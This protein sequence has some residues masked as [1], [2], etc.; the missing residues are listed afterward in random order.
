MGR[1][2]RDHEQRAETTN[3]R[4]RPPWR[5]KRRPCETQFDSRL[6]VDEWSLPHG[7]TDPEGRA[8]TD[9]PTPVGA[10]V[11]GLVAGAIGTAAMDVLLFTRYRRDGGK[12]PFA[13]WELSSGL[14]GW[15]DAPAPAQVGKRLVE[16]LFDL[17][18]PPERAPLV[19]NLTHWGFGMLSGAQYGLVAGSLPRPRIGYGL[20]FGAIVWASGYVVLPAAKLYEPIWKYD[21]KTLGN[22]LRAHLVYGLATAAAWRLISS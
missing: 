9:A 6:G 13:H 2:N 3:R 16:G 19:N 22:D 12:T 21:V 1:P 10:V 7:R 14:K 17:E 11:R 8:V 18:L 15:E 4:E 5:R 20:P